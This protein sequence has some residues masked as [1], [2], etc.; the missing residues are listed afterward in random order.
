MVTVATGGGGS[1]AGTGDDDGVN[2]LPS[3]TLDAGRSDG[4]HWAPL[5]IALAFVVRRRRSR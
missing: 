2:G 5:L 1:N 4:R 3:C